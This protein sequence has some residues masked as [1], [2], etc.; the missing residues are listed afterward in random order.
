MSAQDIPL[1][2]GQRHIHVSPHSESFA[3]VDKQLPLAHG[4]KKFLAVH[5]MTLY[6]E[7]HFQLR[8][9]L[10]NRSIFQC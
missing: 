7:P 4:K 9:K 6:F 1:Q 5:F 3:P 2:V 8:N 10:G